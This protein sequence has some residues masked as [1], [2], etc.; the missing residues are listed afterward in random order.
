MIY[1]NSYSLIIRFIRNRA[2]EVYQRHAAARF[3]RIAF[4]NNPHALY[5]LCTRFVNP[6]KP[7]R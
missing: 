6:E 7:H 2:Q 1:Q 3:E 4:L 5:T